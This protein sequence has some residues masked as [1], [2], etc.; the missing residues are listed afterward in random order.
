M[1]PLTG[2]N[3]TFAIEDF[4]KMDERQEMTTTA[5]AAAALEQADL[6]GLKC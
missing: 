1:S 5:A 6:F 4:I 3:D 2:N